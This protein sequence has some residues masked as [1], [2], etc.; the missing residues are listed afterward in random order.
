M[1]F[2]FLAVLF[3]LGIYFTKD[4]IVWKKDHLKYFFSLFDI[5]LLG[6]PVLSLGPGGVWWASLQCHLF[7]CVVKTW[8]AGSCFETV[9]FLRFVPTMSAPLVDAACGSCARGSCARGVP[10]VMFLFPGSFHVCSVG[11]FCKEEPVLLA[12]A[13]TYVTVSLGSG[14]FVLWAIM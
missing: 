3:V 5:F 8:L 13:L 12:H 1:M 4:K 7:P 14:M 6:M 2:C 10:T 11:L 9:L